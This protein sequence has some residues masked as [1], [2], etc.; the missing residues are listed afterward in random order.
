MDDRSPGGDL[1]PEKALT[2]PLA[3]EHRRMWESRCIP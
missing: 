1:A 2:W 3:R